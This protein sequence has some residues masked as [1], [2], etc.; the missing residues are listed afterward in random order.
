[1]RKL[2]CTNCLMRKRNGILFKGMDYKQC[3]LCYELIK[4]EN[5]HSKFEEII[6]KNVG[7]GLFTEVEE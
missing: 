6:K 1:M 5:N 7:N 2:K 3:S 4:I